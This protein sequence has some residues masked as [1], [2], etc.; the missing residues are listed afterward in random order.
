MSCRS[1]TNQIPPFTFD[2][3]PNTNFQVSDTYAAAPGYISLAPGDTV[4]LEHVQYAV[5]P[6]TPSGPVPVTLVDSGTSLGDLN[7]NPVLFTPADG[8]ITVTNAPEPSTLA[9]LGMGGATLVAWGWRR[10]R[11]MS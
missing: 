10:G 7:F 11:A 2:T 5:A 3:F 4:G 6:G 1:A 9:L 8:T